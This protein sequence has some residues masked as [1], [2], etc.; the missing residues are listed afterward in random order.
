[1]NDDSPRRE[2]LSLW[3]FKPDGPFRQLRCH[4]RVAGDEQMAIAQAGA[5]AGVQKDEF[6]L[7]YT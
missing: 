5:G 3:S 1:M 6:K 7:Q 4:D 2:L